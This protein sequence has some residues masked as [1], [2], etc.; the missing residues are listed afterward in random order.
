LGSSFIL[1]RFR[2]RLSDEFG[3]AADPFPDTV[4]DPGLKLPA[5]H[6]WGFKK[7]IYSQLHM[8]VLLKFN[9]DFQTIVSLASL[10]ETIEAFYTSGLDA[11]FRRVRI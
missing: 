11:V 9:Y 10:F 3:L 6:L 8:P 7:I 2:P 4:P 1:F 5:R